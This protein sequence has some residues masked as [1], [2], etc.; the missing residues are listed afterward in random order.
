MNSDSKPDRRHQNNEQSV[1]E[2][3]HP[4]FQSSNSQQNTILAECISSKLFTFQTDTHSNVF[5]QLLHKTRHRDIVLLKVVGMH[6]LRLSLWRWY[7]AAVQVSSAGFR[8]GAGMTRCWPVIP[9][10]VVSWCWVVRR[11]HWAAAPSS[12]GTDSV[13][14]PRWAVWQWTSW[15]RTAAGELTVSHSSCHDTSAGRLTW[16]LL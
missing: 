15:W 16:V 5:K 12:V 3:T 6:R 7:Y 14:R 1:I 11:W 13:S 9:R 4:S 8:G 10:V 2:Q